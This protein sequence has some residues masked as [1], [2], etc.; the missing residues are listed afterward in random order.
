M[1]SRKQL[2]NI[3]LNTLFS[4]VLPASACWVILLSD[5]GFSLVEIGIFESIF[6]LASFCFE[7][8]SG[9]I[10]DIFGKRRCMIFSGFSLTISAFFMLIGNS[11]L[12][13]IPAMICSAAGYSFASGA[14]EALVYDSL[15]AEDKTDKYLEFVANDSAIYRLFRAVATLMTGYTRKTGYIIAYFIDIILSSVSTY[16]A[17]RL[18]EIKKPLISKPHLN[19]I[20][21]A[22]INTAT[23]SLNFL[24]VNR[25]ASFI[26]IINA[27][28]GIFA[29]LL[30]FFLQPYLTMNGVDGLY[31]GI[32]LF[33][34]SL[35]GVF[36]SKCAASTSKIS[37]QKILLLSVI[38]ISSCFMMVFTRIP[39][40]M[41]LCG[42]IA[43][44]FD[45]IIE[46]RSNNALNQMIPEDE[47]ATL[48]SVNS[49]T[50]S[51]FMIIMSPVI[52]WL[53]EI[54]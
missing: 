40:I 49:F 29:V 5:R 44:F 3:Y 1:S 26:I 50:Y 15:K 11:C 18:K 6:H 4:A 16:F 33:I 22:F 14:R 34:I 47:R 25:K 36:G 13:I 8:P 27:L 30:S 42:F 31:L 19:E 45:D 54:L 24:I 9:M 2:N 38:T 28:C 10:A 51:L 39:F 7:I 52:G 43:S 17:F 37:Y 20:R 23:N 35:G 53:F 12:N 21:N 48:I 32:A 46:I 41:I